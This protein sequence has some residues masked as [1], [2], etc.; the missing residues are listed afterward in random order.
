MVAFGVLLTVHVSCYSLSSMGSLTSIFLLINF[1]SLFMFS[2]LPTRVLATVYP[3]VMA[4]IWGIGDELFD[5][6]LNAILGMLFKHETVI[7]I[8]LLWFRHLL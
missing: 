6:Q 3:L 7:N 1:L 4:V 2:S 8:C 5:T